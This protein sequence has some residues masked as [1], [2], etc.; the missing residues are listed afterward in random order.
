MKHESI[1]PDCH[2]CN[3]TVNNYFSSLREEDI[4]LLNTEKFCTLYKKDQNIFME[5]ASSRGLYCLYN[6]KVKLSKIDSNGKEQI[7]RLVAPGQLFGIKS[8]IENKKFSANAISMEDSI[9]C[10]IPRSR[11]LYLIKKYPELSRNI[12]ITLSKMLDEAEKRMTSIALKSVRERVAESLVTLTNTYKTSD[13]KMKI[14]ISR[15]DLAH[16][17]GSATENVIRTL[18]DFKDENLI[19][20]EGKSIIILDIQGLKKIADL[21]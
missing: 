19:V 14:K 12:L 2:N 20:V 13:N 17:V 4:K 21:I 1:S 18:S 15:D 9:I 8:I 11:I 6:G 16:C 3:I 10:L 7:V 5:G